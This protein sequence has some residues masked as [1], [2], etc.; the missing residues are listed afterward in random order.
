MAIN[1]VNIPKEDGTSIAWKK[2]YFFLI[3]GEKNEK[4][5]QT[6]ALITAI[7]KLREICE[8]QGRDEIEIDANG[9]PTQRS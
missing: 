5:L 3:I 4:T 8:K 1:S 6:P 2:Y 7:R 9:I